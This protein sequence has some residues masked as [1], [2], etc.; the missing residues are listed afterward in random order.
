MSLA[1]RPAPVTD[2]WRVEGPRLTALKQA[3]HELTLLE[4]PTPRLESV[5]IAL[6][7]RECAHAERTAAL[8]T[9][10][11][12]LARQVRTALSRWGIIPQDTSGQSISE[13]SRGLFLRQTARVLGAGIASNNL[14]SLLKNH[15]ANSADDREQ[16]CQWTENFELHLRREGIFKVDP[17]TAPKWALDQEGDENLEEWCEWVANIAESGIR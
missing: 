9:P 10:D 16:H 2:Q 4:S 15:C 13:T 12:N 8:V 7:L 17:D 14:I 11:R 6:K 5:A 1:L 3:T